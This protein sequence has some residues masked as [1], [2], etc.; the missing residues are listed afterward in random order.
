[1]NM[2]GFVASNVMSSVETWYVYDTGWWGPWTLMAT[3]GD[4]P[5]P[6]TGPVRKQY[7]YAG[8]DAS[9]R[10][11]QTVDRMT[12]G[13]SGGA[14]SNTV[15]WT[16]AAK[17]FGSLGTPDSPLNPT[18]YG[19]V[20]PGFSQARLIPVDASSGSGNGA[21]D[22]E[23][24]RHVNEH[25]PV[26]LAVGPRASSC[27][28]CQQLVVWEDPAFRA[29][30]IAWLAVNSYRCTLRPPGGGGGGGGGGGRRRGH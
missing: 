15:L 29:E 22:V 12:P 21:F 18:C 11:L 19:L 9:F 14:R 30:G 8:A 28:Y 5:F 3:D 7:N 2:T 16:A 25:L 4:D 17:A 26:Y 6:V 1:V 13:I 27:W 23:W 10:V 20:L 24:R